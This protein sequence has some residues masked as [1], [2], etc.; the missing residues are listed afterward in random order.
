MGV[1]ISLKTTLARGP[2]NGMPVILGS[3]QAQVVSAQD[4]LASI[5]PSEGSV[6]PCEVFIT[7]SA[8]QSTA[9]F[10]MESVA[11]IVSGPAPKKG[12]PITP[13]APR[14]RQFGAQPVVSQSVPTCCSRFH[15]AIQETNRRSIRTQARV[16]NQLRTTRVTNGECRRQPI[17]R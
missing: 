14:G 1:N 15:K 2:E 4:G 10:Q 11:A 8:G 12:H 6:G 5:V 3:S 16:R 13:S 17:P 7:V 9:Q